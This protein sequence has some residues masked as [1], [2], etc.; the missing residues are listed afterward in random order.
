MQLRWFLSLSLVMHP[1]GTFLSKAALSSRI[2]PESAGQ[3]QPRLP[4][5]V[6]N[7][8]PV[9]PDPFSRPSRPI[10]ITLSTKFPAFHFA[11]SQ[12]SFLGYFL[13]ALVS[14]VEV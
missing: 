4:L 8:R 7:H 13:C 14:S 2:L 1:F 6:L 11:V 5:Q 12:H 10:C 3:V 9:S